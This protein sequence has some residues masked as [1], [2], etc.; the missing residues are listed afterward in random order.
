[1]ALTH[2]DRLLLLVKDMRERLETCNADENCE[3]WAYDE[4]NIL[5]HTVEQFLSR[6][7]RS[8][9]RKREIGRLNLNLQLRIVQLK[10]EKELVATLRHDYQEVVS[11]RN[12]LQVLLNNILT[13]PNSGWIITHAV[14]ASCGMQGRSLHPTALEDGQKDQTMEC[15]RCHSMTY[16]AQKTVQVAE[17]TQVQ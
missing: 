7:T 6:D 4:G 12:N 11:Q 5:L 3:N 14:C 8:L 16:A 13:T 17:P 9:N 2:H 1:M 10:L 15:P